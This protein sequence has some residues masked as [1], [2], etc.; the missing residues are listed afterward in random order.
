[1]SNITIVTEKCEIK[2]QLPLKVI[3]IF[4]WGQW[5]ITLH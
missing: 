4:I 1:M 5:E 3:D 2:T